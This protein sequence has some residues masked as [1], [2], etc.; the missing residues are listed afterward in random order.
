MIEA[1]LDDP[2]QAIAEVSAFVGQVR[3][4]LSEA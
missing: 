2:D 4:A 1:H 3:V